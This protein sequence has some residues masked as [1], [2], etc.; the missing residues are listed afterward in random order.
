MILDNAI[1]PESHPHAYNFPILKKSNFFKNKF[2]K[3][4]SFKI[5][6]STV[7]IY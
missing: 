6:L 3:F 7:I 1:N 2:M 5:I 4:V